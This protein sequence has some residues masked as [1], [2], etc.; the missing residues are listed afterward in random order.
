MTHKKT[1]IIARILGVVGV[2]ILLAEAFD[3][4]TVEINLLIFIAIACFIIGGLVRFIGK[5]QEK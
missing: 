3:V 4:I 2:L 5:Q 1:E